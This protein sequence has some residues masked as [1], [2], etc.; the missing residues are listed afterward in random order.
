MAIVDDPWRPGEQR[1]LNTQGYSA[2]RTF[3]RE[4]V[5]KS[6]LSKRPIPQR[7]EERSPRERV[8]VRFLPPR[9]KRCKRARRDR[10]AGTF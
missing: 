4:I 1:E 2:K 7:H 6:D 5:R 8:S 3:Q 9:N 10:T